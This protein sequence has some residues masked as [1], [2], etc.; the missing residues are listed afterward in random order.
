VEYILWLMEQEQKIIQ[1]F[2]I[3][4]NFRLKT[5]DQKYDKLLR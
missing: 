5:G 4:F 2:A 1:N 3:F